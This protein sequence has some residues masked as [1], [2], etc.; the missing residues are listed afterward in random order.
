MSEYWKSTPKYWCKHCSTYV[1]DTPLE[2]KQH[3][4]TGKHQGNLRRF[5]RDIQNNHERGERDKERAKAEVERLKGSQNAST[6]KTP[7]VPATQ[8]Q[9]TSGPLSAAD[10]KRQW[11]QLAEMGIQVPEQFR[12]EMAIPGDWS[13]LPTSSSQDLPPEDPLS[14]GVRKRKATDEEE[15]EEL[16]HQ[17]PISR[18]WGN[19]TKVFPGQDSSDLSSLLSGTVALSKK[20]IKAKGEATTQ[21]GKPSIPAKYKLEPDSEDVKSSEAGS[22]SKQVGEGLE[23][24]LSTKPIIKTEENP[25]NDSSQLDQTPAEIQVPVF[26]KRKPKG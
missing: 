9:S 1:K 15:E 24:S 17:A 16:I 8:R 18:G 21:E 3:E 10:Q 20:S 7:S 14:I 4:A 22:L 5:L 19:T 23:H 11:S 25:V 26:K 13:S 2:R 6:T 12:S